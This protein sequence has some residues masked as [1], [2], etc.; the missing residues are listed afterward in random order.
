MNNLQKRLEVVVKGYTDGLIPV[1]HVKDGQFVFLTADSNI[2]VNEYGYVQN[3]RVK[4]DYE[5]YGLTFSD[6]LTVTR[7][8]PLYKILDELMKSW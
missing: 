2:I 7:K 5:V 8:N 3:G 1:K 6:C 4:T